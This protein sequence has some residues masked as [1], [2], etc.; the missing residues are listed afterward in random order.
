[1][2]YRPAAMAH[3]MTSSGA[4]S[5]LLSR[6]ALVVAVLLVAPA[7][8]LLDRLPPPGNPCEDLCAIEDEC[9]LR[10]FDDCM[11][12]SCGDA[13]VRSGSDADECMLSVDN[14]ADVAL[15]T[16]DDSCAKL[17]E[18]TGSPDPSCAET[19]ESLV[20]QDV[21]GTF[22]ENRCRIESTCEELALCTGL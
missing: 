18:C 17:D 15:C 2:W 22:Q 7:C 1:M 16:C 9:G 21:V 12:E 6:V 13:G 19:C 4:R 5:S 20:E 3:R 10:S 14:C 11:A 8:E